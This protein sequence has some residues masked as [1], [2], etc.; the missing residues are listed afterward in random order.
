MIT[1]K[2]QITAIENFDNVNFK[3]DSSFLQ[4]FW[5]QQLTR[6]GKSYSYVPSYSHLLIYIHLLIF[7][8]Q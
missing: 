5:M 7:S 2:L 3:T 4:F 6:K 8:L 1:C